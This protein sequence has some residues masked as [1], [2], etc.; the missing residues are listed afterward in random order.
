MKGPAVAALFAAVLPVASCAQDPAPAAA[1][2]RL[3]VLCSVDQLAAW[4]FAA[5]KPHFAADGGFRRLLRDGAEFAR[6]EYEHACTETGP[7]HATIGTGVPARV[8]GIV[9]NKWWV[10]SRSAT[11][12]CV[13]EVVAP[14]PDLP[15]GRNRG[16][17]LLLAPTLATALEAASPTSHTVSVAWKDRSAILMAGPKADLAVWCEAGTGRFVTNTAWVSSTPP[18]LTA[19][20]ERKELDRLFGTVWT[21][22]G[23]DT[24]YEGLV[25]DRPYETAHANG[26]GQRTL[27]QPLT[28]GA[29]RPGAGLYNQ[30]YLS[31]FGNTIVRQA[32]EAAVRGLQLG[33]DA[34]TDLLCVGFSSTDTVGHAYGPDS[35]EAR[36]GL[37]RLDRELATF[38]A[39]LDAEVGVGQWA[40]FLT[41][42]HG[43]GPTPEWAR[44]QGIDAGRGLIQ[45]MVGAA[46]ERA[47]V[48]TF[49][50][51]PAGKRYVSHIGEYSVFFDDAVLEATRG[52]RSLEAM[53]AAASQVAAAAAVKVRGLD[54]AFATADLLAE[55]GAPDA[56]RRSLVDALCAGRAGEVQL[57]IKPYWLDGATPASHGTPH[58]YDREVV[59]LAIGRGV[60]AGAPIAATVTP[61]FGAVWFAQMLG[62]PRP[63]GANDQV[64]A[65]FGA[66]W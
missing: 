25:D 27:P 50:P 2:P 1:R 13:D 15:E 12:Y 55:G 66:P 18:W 60:P 53:R 49:G 14:L 43:V 6:C 9:R 61:G 38:L 57:V 16:A 29:D 32:A 59:G 65:A 54:A 56:L 3:V 17:G 28:G 23:P 46:V 47:L 20:N 33:A 63:A 31:P 30:I 42:D 7:G 10:R 8:H 22:S 37:L 4:V 5:G 48:T 51:A 40:M 19:F 24:A 26:L 34:S 52:E 36:D 44:T 45:T 39:F 41:A 35:V 62:L 58:P 11:T 64:P 21:R